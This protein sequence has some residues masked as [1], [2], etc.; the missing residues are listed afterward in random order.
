M[1]MWVGIATESNH[2]PVASADMRRGTNSLAAVHLTLWPKTNSSCLYSISLEIFFGLLYRCLLQQIAGKLNL[3]LYL[4]DT[5]YL[6]RSLGTQNTLV[7]KV[8]PQLHFA[9][10]TKL[11]S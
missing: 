2:G 5:E 7:P 1:I 11:P 10:S 9:V 6:L 8:V 4:L 3:I